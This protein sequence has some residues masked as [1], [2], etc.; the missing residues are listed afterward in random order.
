MFPDF[1]DCALQE[2][3]CRLVIQRHQ[4]ADFIPLHFLHEAVVNDFLLTGTEDGEVFFDRLLLIQGLFEVDVFIFDGWLKQE[5]RVFL[6]VTVVS[7][8][9]LQMSEQ[10]VLECNEKIDLYVFGRAEVMPVPVKMRKN[11]VDTVLHIFAV[12]RKVQ[13][14]PVKTLD[15]FCV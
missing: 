1:P 3:L 11:V 2:V 5:R 6:P 4:A 9:I 13:S 10:S 12:G 7:V 8:I 15:V 14:I